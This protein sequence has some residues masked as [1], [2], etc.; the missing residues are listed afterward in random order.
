MGRLLFFSLLLAAACG[1]SGPEVSHERVVIGTAR[2]AGK[3]KKPPE[4]FDEQIDAATEDLR[5]GR[6]EEGL[7]RVVAAKA[8][9]PEEGDLADLDDLLRRLNRA[10]LDLPTLEVSVEPEKDPIVFD[11]PVRVRIK[12]RNP[13]SRTVRVRAR[14]KKGSR[15]I[16]VIDC[17][18]TEYDVRAQ[19]VR[20]RRQV[21]I[22]LPQDV[23][24]PPRATTEIVLV[25]EGAG[26]DRP[27]EGFRTFLVGG[28]LRAGAIELDGLRRYEAVRMSPG[29]VRSFRP[30]YEHLKEDPVAR[31]KQAL[32]RSSPIHLL[33]ATAL[34]PPEGRAEAVD[35]L[36]GALE[37]AGPMD[38]SAIAC[39]E[40]L[41][42]VELGRD[43][44]A[45]RAWWSRVGDRF[46]AAPEG[47]G[48]GEGPRF[49]K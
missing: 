39:L 37:G 11:E 41:T 34:V 12:L 47:E 33:T 3:P 22:P 20:S 45:W 8:Q 10:V 6:L 44:D 24:L 46:F 5:A 28:Q 48:C 2:P 13:G 9:N 25:V 19:V 15:S 17:L 16:F 26:N 4:W 1:T 7:K 30:N 31:V 27:L 49:S 40:Y 42:N 29:T 21:H 38:L 14:P 18:R 23:E 36:V 43:A 35:A 32:E